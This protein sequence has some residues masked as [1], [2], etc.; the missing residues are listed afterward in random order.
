MIIFSSISLVKR[1]GA[2]SPMTQEGTIVGDGFV[3]SCYAKFPH[4]LANIVMYPTR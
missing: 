1:C 3:S 2:Y 4:K